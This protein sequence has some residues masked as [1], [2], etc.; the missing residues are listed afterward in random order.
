MRYA[1]L[2][3]LKRHVAWYT[4]CAIGYPRSSDTV[5][6]PN[7]IKGAVLRIFGREVG[8]CR[9]LF[10]FYDAVYPKWNTHITI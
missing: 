7:R 8:A 5:L 9:P 1:F 10:S 3:I 4:V 6:P 2:I